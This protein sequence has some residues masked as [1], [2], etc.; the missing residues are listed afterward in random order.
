MIESGILLGMDTCGSM[1]SI[2]LARLQNGSL[3]LLG[4]R[5]I[6]GGELSVALVQGIADLLSG[7]G[8]AVRDVAGITAVVGPGS[9]T[10]IRVGLAAVKGLAEAANLPVVTLSRLALLA[11][12]AQAP[13]AVLDAHRGQFY[14]GMC[15]S[16]EPREMLLTAGEINS[17]G[18]LTG[19]VAVCEETVAQLL[20][21]LYGE[22]ELIRVPAPTAAAALEVSLSKWRCGEL[23][24][25]ALLD[26][27]YLRGADAKVSVGRG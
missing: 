15:D 5:E 18:G 22:P 7:A 8:V 26:G 21:E 12:L 16:G 24:D 9:F 19:R 13:C 6:A 10:G 25:V 14:Y 1:G 2:A 3:S 17:M 4:E 11:D 23:A 20:E 27:Y